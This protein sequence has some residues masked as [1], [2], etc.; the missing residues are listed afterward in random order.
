M[1]S[2]KYYGIILA[3]LARERPAEGTATKN[4][5]EKKMEPKDTAKKT[6]ACGCAFAERW[7]SWE[8]AIRCAHLDD[9]CPYAKREVDLPAEH[10]SN[11]PLPAYAATNPMERIDER[12]LEA[13]ADF[14]GDG[15]MSCD[16][17]A[18]HFYAPACGSITCIHLGSQ[19]KLAYIAHQVEKRNKMRETAK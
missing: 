1:L 9:V 18:H 10:A 13:I 4:E 6:N 17:L 2:P 16:A 19:L 11:C 3:F 5:K 8:N 14:F 7:E 12:E 15:C